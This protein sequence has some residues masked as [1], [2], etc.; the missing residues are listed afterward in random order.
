MIKLGVYRPKSKNGVLTDIFLLSDEVK[1][2]R[3]SFASQR[4]TGV[5]AVA[6][7]TQ[8]GVRKMFSTTLRQH[9]RLQLKNFEV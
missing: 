6:D 9:R 4:A 8:C 3:P 7:R 1:C 2:P 5:L